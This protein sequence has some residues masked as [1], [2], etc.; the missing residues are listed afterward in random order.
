MEPVPL[1]IYWFY[2][3][4]VGGIETLLWDIGKWF[5]KNEVDAHFLVGTVEEEEAVTT[6]GSVT[7]E[8]RD[9]LKRSS[10]G[11]D[12]GK[13]LFQR[14][15]NLVDEKGVNVIHVHNFH[16]PKN[17]THTLAICSA[18]TVKDVPLIL[19]V[20]GF[21]GS[22]VET[23]LLSNMSWDKILGVSNYTSEKLL[24][25]SVKGERIKTVHNSIDTIKYNPNLDKGWL[26]KRLKIDEKDRIIVVSS[27]L[28]RSFGAP[29]AELKGHYT[30]LQAASHLAHVLPNFKIVFTGSDPTRKEECQAAIDNLIERAKILEVEDKL[31]FPKVPFD[32]SDMPLVYAGCDVMALP[33]LHETFGLVFAEAMACGRPV[34]GSNSGGVPEII[35]SGH[36]GMLVE[37]KNAV[38]LFKALEKILTDPIFALKLGMNARKTVEENFSTDKMCKEIMDVYRDVI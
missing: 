7:V 19:H 34:I 8:R 1:H 5:E 17:I 24:G 28:I 10:N 21:S 11:R 12:A 36:N 22:E 3:P 20:H 35:N 9:F 6:S 33:S 31:I 13:A 32:M 26:R 16:V 15:C 38:E 27:R 29:A 25:L 18:A 4:A 14:I 23:L 30:V 2:P 37:E